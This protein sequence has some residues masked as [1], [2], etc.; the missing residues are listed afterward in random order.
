MNSLSIVIPC[1]NE[2]EVL[3][4]TY[5]CITQVCKGLNRNYEIIFVDDGSQDRTYELIK[6]FAKSDKRIGGIRLSRN[7]GKE[8]VLFAG[9]R[10]SRGDLVV[11]MDADLQD[12]PELLIEMIEKIENEGYDQVGTY[13]LSRKSQSMSTR[14]FS[15][16]YYRTYN[17]FSDRPIVINEREYRMF[18]RVALDTLLSL[19]ETNR[20]FKG[21]WTWI[22]FK[23]HYIGYEDIDRA[24][25]K[26]KYNIHNKLKLAAH[27]IFAANIQPLKWVHLITFIFWMAFIVS[28]LVHNTFDYG[29]MTSLILGIAALQFSIFSLFA[30]YLGNIYLESKQRPIFVAKESFSSTLG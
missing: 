20:Y 2:E 24:K 4:L 19:H 12:P 11:I 30:I 25:G 21:L 28:C 8:G 26:T 16:L 5:E 27:N 14:I 6:S 29:W 9:L 13:R 22:G 18:S 10:A 1:Y 15:E 3:P 7:F 23:T 17:L